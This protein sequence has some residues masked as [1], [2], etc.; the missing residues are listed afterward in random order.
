[1]PVLVHAVRSRTQWYNASRMR[2]PLNIFLSMVLLRHSSCVHSLV[3]CV[4]VLA[5]MLYDRVRE[6]YSYSVF[7]LLHSIVPA[8]LVLYYRIHPRRLWYNSYLHALFRAVRSRSRTGTVP[9]VYWYCCTPCLHSCCTTAY[10]PVYCGT[11]SHLRTLLR[12]VRS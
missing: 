12:N 7:V 4:R 6:Q 9:L 10:T 3:L 5:T 11:N 8:L 2:T 1:M